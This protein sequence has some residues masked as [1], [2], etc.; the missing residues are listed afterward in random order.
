VEAVQEKDYK[1]AYRYISKTAVQEAQARRREHFFRVTKPRIVQMQDPR[2][3]QMA[4]DLEGLYVGPAENF[5]IKTME[6]LEH[7][8]GAPFGSFEVLSESIDGD[9]AKVLCRNPDGK[10]EEV[11]LIKENGRWGLLLLAIKEQE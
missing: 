9:I 7:S 1:A 3:L 5:F 8:L 4:L 2:T 10:E 6:A 11:R